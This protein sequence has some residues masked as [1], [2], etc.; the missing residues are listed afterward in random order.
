MKG[1]GAVYY[2]FTKIFETNKKKMLVLSV[3]RMHN[4]HTRLACKHT[5]TESV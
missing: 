4:F 3:S 5:Q 1:I 2:S